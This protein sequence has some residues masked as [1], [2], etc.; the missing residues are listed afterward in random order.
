MLYRRLKDADHLV[1][2][3]VGLNALAG[4]G[5]FEE[6]DADSALFVGRIDVDDIPGARGRDVRQHV[7]DEVAMGVEQA[8][9]LS[10]GDVL[11]HHVREEGRLTGAGR[12]EYVAVAG[13]VGYGESHGAALGAALDVSELQAFAGQHGRCMMMFD[14]ESETRQ[15]FVGWKQR[16]QAPAER[17]G[18]SEIE[19]TRR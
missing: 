13:P 5:D 11:H 4:A 3:E 2:D 19:R 1:R 10:G 18:V 17:V 15:V 14:G 16:G 8:D 7:A 6:V 9:T 12:T